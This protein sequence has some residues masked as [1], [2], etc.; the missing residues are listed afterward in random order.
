MKDVRDQAVICHPLWQVL[1]TILKLLS[2]LQ[3]STYMVNIEPA[4]E[5]RRPEL[6]HVAGK[7][8]AKDMHDILGRM[9]GRGTMRTSRGPEVCEKPEYKVKAGEYIFTV[10][11]H[12]GQ[13]SLELANL[14]HR[15]YV[16]S[17]SLF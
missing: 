7:H 17:A 10:N 8:N 2:V 9:H 13:P 14:C 1:A 15:T 12:P 5:G 4:M 6:F 11:Q 16:S 3:T